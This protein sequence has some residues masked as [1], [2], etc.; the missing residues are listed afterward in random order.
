MASP[1]VAGLVSYIR[2]LEGAMD[3]ETV[4]ARVLELATTGRVTDRKN[5]QDR[6]AYNGNGR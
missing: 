5:S 2:G 1:H 3:A 4:T 6:L